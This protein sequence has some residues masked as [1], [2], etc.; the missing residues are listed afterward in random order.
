M[1]IVKKKKFAS[2]LELAINNQPAHDI[3]TT[4]GFG[5]FW[6]Q[7]QI[8]L[9]QRCHNVVFPTSLL[10]PKT[11]VVTTCFRGRLSDLV[12]TLQQRRDFEVV[13][14]TKI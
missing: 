2:F 13:F 5:F 8:T 3:V 4:L 6:T 14:L 12:L 9:S 1:Q 7:R 10:L 11:N